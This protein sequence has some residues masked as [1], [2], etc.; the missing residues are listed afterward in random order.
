M[1]FAMTHTTYLYLLK[2]HMFIWPIL[3]FNRV[4]LTTSYISPL[5]F[6]FGFITCFLC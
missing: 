1:L 5:L 2:L 6:E 4:A 3:I